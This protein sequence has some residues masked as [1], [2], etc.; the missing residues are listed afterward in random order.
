MTEHQDTA[1]ANRRD[2]EADIH[3]DLAGRV[4]YVIND[5]LSATKG[6]FAEVP[7]M[8]TSAH[9]REPSSHCM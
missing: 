7:A 6:V 8:R 9:D 5:L 1:S 2:L 3:T 4:T